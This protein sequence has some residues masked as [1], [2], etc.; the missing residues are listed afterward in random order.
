MKTDDSLCQDCIGRIPYGSLVSLFLCWLGVGLFCGMMYQAVSI[1]LRQAQD[2]LD[3]DIPFLANIRLAFILVAGV[4]VFVALLL[5]ILGFLSTGTTR[6]QVYS[7]WRSRIGGR[8]SCAIFIIITYLLYICWLLIFSISAILVFVYSGFSSLCPSSFSEK[9]KQCWN[10]TQIAKMFL[11]SPVAKAL[12]VCAENLQ[13][14]CTLTE[15]ALPLYIAAYVG[16]ALV[17]LGLVHYL[18]CLASNYV[19][20]KHGSKYFELEEI[21][22]DFGV[23]QMKTYRGAVPNDSMM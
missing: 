6:R 21:K 10:F 16:G 23:H 17:L 3:M 8:I 20:I 22:K 9:E 4:M 19:H 2:V 12:T 11:K 13:K 1:S 15:S 5:L 7:G 18:I 14:F